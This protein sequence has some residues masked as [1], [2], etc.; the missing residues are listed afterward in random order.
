MHS[1]HKFAIIGLMKTCVKFAEFSRSVLHASAT[2]V[3]V[4]VICETF[5]S[6]IFV[7]FVFFFYLVYLCSG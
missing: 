7:C 5:H 3:F 6:K 1:W 4:S 2:F